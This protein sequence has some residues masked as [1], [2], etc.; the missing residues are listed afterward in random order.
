MEFGCEDNDPA[1]FALG[2]A[3][4]CSLHFSHDTIL[5]S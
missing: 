3:A 2:M 1:R 5:A 4:N